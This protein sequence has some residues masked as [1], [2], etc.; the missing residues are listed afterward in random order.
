MLI[1]TDAEIMDLLSEVGGFS[2]NADSYDISKE[3]V[4][5]LERNNI[6]FVILTAKD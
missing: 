3:Q 1:E 6:P 2:F 4:F 5:M